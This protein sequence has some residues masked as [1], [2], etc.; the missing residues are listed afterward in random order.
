[1]DEAPVLTEVRE[2]YRLITLNRPDKLNSFNTAMHAALAAALDEAEADLDCRAVVLTGAGRAFCAGQ[3]L[4]DRVTPVGG[5]APDLGSTLE[6]SYNPLIRKLHALPFPIVA[7][8]NGTAA[9]AGANIALNCDI[10]LAAKSAK[11]IQAFAKIGLVPDSGGTWVLP[12]LV[13]MARARAL[14][15]TA[16]PVDAETAAAWGMIWK[17]VDDDALMD[18][19]TKL[20]GAFAKAATAGLAQQKRILDASWANDLNAQLDLERDTQRQL[21]RHPDY[22]EGVRAFMEKRPPAFTGRKG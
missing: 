16:E 15:L 7:A 21:G 13:G 4:S 19:A 9:G 6:S 11:F 1:M 3:D 5:E 14:C 8:V 12:R 10:V 17:A 18:E 2:G 22:A 20:A